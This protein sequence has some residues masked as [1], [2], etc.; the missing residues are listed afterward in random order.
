M[1]GL[2]IQNNGNIYL[3]QLQTGVSVECRIKGN[4]RLKGIRSTNPIAIGDNVLVDLQ[5]NGHSFIYDI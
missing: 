2:V 4:F 5:T 3:V 1:Q